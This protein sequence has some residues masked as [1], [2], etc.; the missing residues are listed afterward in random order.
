HPYSFVNLTRHL[1]RITVVLLLAVPVV[2]RAQGKAT[3]IVTDA[4][5]IPRGDLRVRQLTQ[6]TRYDNLFGVPAFPSPTPLASSFSTDSLGTR[7]IPTLSTTERSIRALRGVNAF[8]LPA[9]N[10]V[11]TADSRIVTSPLV[12]EYGVTDRL[13]VGLVVPLVQ[14]RTTFVFALNTS[15]GLANVGANPA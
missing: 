6:W 12:V 8:R 9:G 14:T 3:N 15:L 11:A 2:V 1:I 13:M 10:I 7:E 4:N 5:V